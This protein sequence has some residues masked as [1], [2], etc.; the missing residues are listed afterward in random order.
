MAANKQ[1]RNYISIVCVLMA[2]SQFAL[3]LTPGLIQKKKNE[4][5]WLGRFHKNKKTL[6]MVKTGDE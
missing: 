1:T 5:K 4:K 6:G 2:Q 3:F